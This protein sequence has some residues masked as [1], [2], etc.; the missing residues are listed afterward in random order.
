MDE[1][2]KRRPGRPRTR[3]KLAELRR[4]EP[5]ESLPPTARKLLDGARRILE[6][7]GFSALSLSAVA[8]EADESKGSIGYYF[9][10][11]EGLIVALVDSLVHD[12]NRALVTETHRYP[13][14][15]QR[16]R[17]LVT[18]ERDIIRDTPGF[19][20]LLE[21]LPYAM[22]DDS[23]RERIASLYAGYRKTVL[24]VVDAADGPDEATL[25][26]FAMLM[27]AMVDG[28]SVQYALDPG[29]ADVDAAI[30]MWERMMR[31]LFQELGMV[32]AG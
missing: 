27:I 6:R 9:G 31:C 25:R 22:R 30:K 24:D 2:P 17:A 21:V 14:G 7:G 15:E 32:D 4:E 26:P 11:K 3:E 16:L 1:Q 8:E 18:G 28:L 5:I 13:M 12:A 19:L 23:L 20:A 10:N 29:G